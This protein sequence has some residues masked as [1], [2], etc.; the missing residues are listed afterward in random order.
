MK[1]AVFIVLILLTSA[2]GCLGSPD[3]LEPADIKYENNSL[4][5]YTAYQFEGVAPMG[6]G[7]ES[8]INLNATNASVM[9]NM[10]I[11][12]YFHEPLIW[13]QGFVNISI[14]NDDNDV[15][16]E[17]QSNGGNSE[18]SLVISDNYTF[19]GNLTLRVLS[20]GSDDE[21]DD[22]PGD[23]YIIEYNATAEWVV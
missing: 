13:D 11:Q 7:N 8:I 5:D 6:M 12:S 16:W 22:K 2:A 15:L 3:E 9:M 23:Y 4:E 21:T 17:N 10:T 20:E 19:N 18:V 14:L 1:P